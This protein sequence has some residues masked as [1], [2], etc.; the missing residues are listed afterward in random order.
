MFY[1]LRNI[2]NKEI[3]FG[4]FFKVKSHHCS[5]NSCNFLQTIAYFRKSLK[6]FLNSSHFLTVALYFCIALGFIA[7]SKL[8]PANYYGAYSETHQPTA[9][10]IEATA[11]AAT[12]SPPVFDDDEA[13]YKHIAGI[14]QAGDTLSTSFKRHHISDELRL[15]IIRGLEGHLDFKELRPNDHYAITID[16]KGELI[17]CVYESGPLNIY[18][19]T[20]TPNGFHTEQLRIPLSCETVKIAGTIQN[21]LFAAF[22]QYNE[23]PKLIYAFA[24]IFASKID[25]NTE[26]RKGDRFNIVFEKYY[27]DDQFIGYG[28]ILVARYET[29]DGENF[30]GF[31]YSSDNTPGSYFDATGRELGSSFIRSP[32]PMGR[33]TSGFSFHRKHPILGVVRPHL[34]VDLA[35]PIGTPIMAVAD[36]RVTFSGWKGGYGKLIMLR[37]AN[38]YKTYYG[39]LLRF[40]KGIKPGVRVKQKQVIGYVGMTGITTGPHLHYEVRQ[41][42]TPKNPFAIKFRPKSI[43]EGKELKLFTQARDILTDIALSLEK[44]HE[45]IQVKNVTVTPETEISFL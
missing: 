38:N 4:D 6:I 25:F 8:S 30:E 15:Q 10:L 9:T 43:L 14:L 31:Y 35:A 5:S 7:N 23:D 41:N 39:H 36:G 2:L 18:A 20:R 28:K 27:K 12:S 29:V 13:N 17:K 32:V 33:V 24:D 34:G 40:A 21:S 45:V 44:D 11:E 22:M 37:H 3:N 26:T 1:K 19:I 42:N 16:D